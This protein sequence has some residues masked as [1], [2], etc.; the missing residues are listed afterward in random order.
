[1]NAFEFSAPIGQRGA[2]CHLKFDLQEIVSKP[3]GMLGIGL[4]SSA[5]E[6]NTPAH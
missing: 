1:M 5:C 3:L 4:E 6:E 2:F